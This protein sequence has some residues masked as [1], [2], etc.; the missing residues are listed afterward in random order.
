[1]STHEIILYVNGE[2]Y[3]LNVASNQ[4]LLQ[5]LRDDLNLVGTKYGCGTGECGA[6]TVL[7]DGDKPVLSCLSLAATMNRKEITT[8]EGLEEDGQLHPVQEAFVE[9][10]AVQCGYCTSG[11]IMKTKGLLENNPSPTDQEAREY[12]EG[13]ICR[14]TGYVKILDAVQYA[15]TL[16]EKMENKADK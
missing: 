15:G 3:T 11:M 9:K 7:Q 13:N 5:V 12:L 6:C 8:I 4:T 1:M 16:M 14:C 10:G 2:E